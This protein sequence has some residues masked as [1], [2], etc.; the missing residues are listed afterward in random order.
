MRLRVCPRAGEVAQ[1][2]RALATLPK[3]LSSNPSN[4][5]MTVMGSVTGSDAVFW[6]ALIH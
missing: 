5:A 4:H 2:L 1:Q 3:V 6:K